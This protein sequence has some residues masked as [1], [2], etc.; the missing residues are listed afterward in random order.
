MPEAVQGYVHD[1]SL[2]NKGCRFCCCL[3]SGEAVAV[4]HMVG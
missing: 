1:R 4:E 3:W 2:C